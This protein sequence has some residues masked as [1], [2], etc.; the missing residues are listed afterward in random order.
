M[1]ILD[2]L[3]TIKQKLERLKSLDREHAIFGSEAHKYILKPRLSEDAIAQFEQEHEVALP[4]E[5]RA[6]L[7]HIGNGGAGP[8][9][10]LR[11]LQDALCDIRWVREAFAL[12]NPFPHTERWN[13]MDQYEGTLSPEEYHDVE[14]EYFKDKYVNGSLA[15]CHEGCGYMTLLVVSG[16]ERGHI[17]RD[18]RVSDGGIY[19]IRAWHA[20]PR[21]RYNPLFSSSDDQERIS[22]LDWYEHWLD[23]SLHKIGAQ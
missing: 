20:N 6:F 4:A 18:S 14:T 17:W 23:A 11:S 22:F 15:I 16:E 1:T 12:K 8:Y 3:E 10:G 9:Y 13:L 21:R 5:Y 2:R 19:A 7:L